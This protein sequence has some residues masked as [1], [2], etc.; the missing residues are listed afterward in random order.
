VET[1]T[2]QGSLDV[3]LVEDDEPLARA[4]MLHLRA[5]GWTVRWAEDGDSALTSC[6]ERVPHIVVLD[7]MLPGRS[8]LDVCT[9]LRTAILP[10]P[11]VVMLTARS[12]EGDV[13]LGLDHGADDYVIK[14]CRPRE[15]TA[16][17]RALSRRLEAAPRD[18]RDA[19]P[20]EVVLGT[21]RLDLG[22]RKAQVDGRTLQLT[23]SEFALLEIFMR[24]EG[25]SLSRMVL[26]ERVFDSTHAGYARNVDCH[27]ARL[28]KKLEAT[29]SKSSIETVYGSGYRFVG[30]G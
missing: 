29:G 4:L 11:G 13:V 28:R 15:L 16:R 24:N 8:G 10:S 1:R 25:Q 23:P 14:P 5:E 22:M 7:L 19:W 27:V 12:S 3:L 30:S 21:L 18:A 17:I 20:S 6:R 26:L 2:D 9:E